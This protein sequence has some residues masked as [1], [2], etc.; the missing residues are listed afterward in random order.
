[1]ISNLVTG[2]INLSI[3]TLFVSDLPAIIILVI[4]QAAVIG[5]LH[6]FARK[7]IKVKFW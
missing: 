3:F 7:G 5:L 4:Y 6:V 2:A 1:M